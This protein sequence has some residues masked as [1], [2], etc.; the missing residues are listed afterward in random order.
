MA[1]GTCC[2]WTWT[3]SQLYPL[4]GAIDATLD[5]SVTAVCI[6]CCGTETTVLYFYSSNSIPKL[7]WRPWQI[8]ELCSYTNTMGETALLPVRAQRMPADGQAFSN[9]AGESQFKYRWQNGSYPCVLRTCAQT[10]SHTCCTNKRHAAAA[11]AVAAARHHL[12]NTKL[13]MQ[14]PKWGVHV[15]VLYREGWE[16]HIG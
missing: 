12:Q 5:T 11:S 3:P 14:R 2:C 10:Q 1:C 16:I 4:K 7:E 9:D 15:V 6:H 13:N 8:S